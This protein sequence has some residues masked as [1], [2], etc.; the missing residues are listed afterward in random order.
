MLMGLTFDRPRDLE[1]AKR[2]GNAY[3]R[4]AN[5]IGLPS[6]FELT[7]DPSWAEGG[8]LFTV[9]DLHLD[10]DDCLINRE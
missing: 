5:S 1:K 10:D 8:S 7:G 2:S 3:V 4:L 6:P 9:Y